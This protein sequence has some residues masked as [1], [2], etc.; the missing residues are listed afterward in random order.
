[1]AGLGA[2][3]ENFNSRFNVMRSQKPQQTSR[4]IPSQE[5]VA[6]H[7]QCKYTE[8]LFAEARGQMTELDKAQTAHQKLL[9]ATTPIKK[10]A[11]G[12]NVVLP[13]LEKDPITNLRKHI[14][15]N[16]I[17]AFNKGPYKQAEQ[18]SKE[19]Q[20]E[21]N[22]ANLNKKK[23]AKQQHIS[24]CQDT[25]VTKLGLNC[26]LKHMKTVIVDLLKDVSQSFR[27]VNEFKHMI[28]NLQIDES[29]HQKA[30]DALQN[31]LK[32][33]YCEF[34]QLLHLQHIPNA[35]FTTSTKPTMF[36]NVLDSLN[37]RI[38]DLSKSAKKKQQKKR[39]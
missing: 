38:C 17:E 8:T 14:P 18:E 10:N 3:K 21:T 29:D 15:A 23:E 4:Q 32:E 26:D 9:K 30:R 27:Y 24:Q 1:M 12:R 22:K 28:G 6:M 5:A 16:L 2:V 25:V 39:M 36:K 13:A 35:K 31:E 11:N 7:N 34:V 20:R 33:R 37:K 19:S